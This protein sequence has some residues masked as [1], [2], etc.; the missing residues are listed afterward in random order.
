MLKS[1]SI[2]N[3]GPMTDVAFDLDP[4]LNVITGD[5]GLG[6]SLLLDIAFWA[7]SGLWPRARAVPTDGK[8]RD[9]ELE[10]TI[11]GLVDA[12]TSRTAKYDPV[13]EGWR[14]VATGGARM[15]RPVIV[16]AMVD[17][18]FAVFDEARAGGEHQDGIDLFV[19][20][21]RESARRSR[22][23]KYGNGYCVFTAAEVFDGLE[24][25]NGRAANG[26]I[27]DWS[28]WQYRHKKRFAALRSTLLTLSEGIGEAI[29]PARPRK[30]S[31]R[32]SR[33][34]PWIGLPYG[35]IPITQ[36]SAAM[37]RILGLAYMLVW[38]WEEHVEACK[39]THT[40][41]TSEMLF[42]FDEVECHLHP[43]WQR[44]ILPALLAAIGALV[45]QKTKPQIIAATHSPLVLA[46]LEPLFDETRDQL[47]L[48]ELTEAK[49]VAV[50]REPFERMGR[51]D[52]WLMS[53]MFGLGA[54]TSVEAQAALAKATHQLSSGATPSLAAIRAAQ[55]DL[56]AVVSD[57]DPMLAR[58]GPVL[59]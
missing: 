26:L 31:I 16:Y 49:K 8:R 32:D 41:Q 51:A 6:K 46:S 48:I 34:V 45:G 58:L 43:K 10:W 5:N 14:L 29:K 27:E 15:P 53:D 55:R 22:A 30:T 7:E 42:L 19:D 33:E 56:A 9:A 54:P 28:N 50:R 20:D 59:N 35:E 13:I 12:S 57:T 36:A 39:L 4:R 47:L 40:P 11:H 38:A 21:Q 23:R 25:D 24:G 3:V 44:V 1:L 37:R 2:Q 18:G 52:T 17:G